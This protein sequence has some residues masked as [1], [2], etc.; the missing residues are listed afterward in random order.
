M[1]KLDKY[2]K[3]NGTMMH[4]M[5]KESTRWLRDKLLLK[6]PG[7]MVYF[8]ATFKLRIKMDKSLQVSILT[9][10]KMVLVKFNIKMGLFLMVILRTISLM[11]SE[12]SL[13]KPSH[14]K[15]TL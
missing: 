10:R 2:M 6:A 9:T 8:T 3:E 5:A 13:T 1:Q 14:T 4:G 12:K 7:K 15:E 11:G